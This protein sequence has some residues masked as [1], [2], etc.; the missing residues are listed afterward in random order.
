MANG[1]DKNAL[2]GLMKKAGLGARSRK[3]MHVANGTAETPTPKATKP[4]GQGAA[5]EHVAQVDEL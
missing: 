1:F 4:R 2:E 3:N 5:R